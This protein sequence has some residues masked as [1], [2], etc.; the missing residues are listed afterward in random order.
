MDNISSNNVE[1]AL[2]KH[3]LV[4]CNAELK[5]KQ[6]QD[7][8][9]NLEI[10]TEI[11][12]PKKPE[13]LKTGDSFSISICT[14][15]IG[16][17]KSSEKAIFSF[18]CELEGDYRLVKCAKSGIA[19]GKNLELWALAII[20]LYPLVSQFVTDTTFRMG[21]KNVNIPPFI[22]SE[23]RSHPPKKNPPQ[24]SKPSK[25]SFKAP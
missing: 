24:K 8:G 2:L 13:I 14:T 23:I 18:S 17:P 19:T 11:N 10:T 4:K 1:V 12:T 7:S 9:G 5:S 21:I 15:V 25:P 3:R 16:K 20:Q 22:L 6:E